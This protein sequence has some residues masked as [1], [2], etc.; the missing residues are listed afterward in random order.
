M[1]TSSY[2]EL[3]RAI[4]RRS[5][6]LKTP[7]RKN[8]TNKAQTEQ[9]LIGLRKDREKLVKEE[10]L[11]YL[12]NEGF[13]DTEANAEAL[14]DVMSEQWFSSILEAIAATRA[15]VRGYQKIPGSAQRQKALEDRKEEAKRRAE[16]RKAQV[17]KE[18][19]YARQRRENPNILKREAQKRTLSTR[20]ERAAERL[21]L[22]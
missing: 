22:D 1:D 20:M 8:Q 12:I 6:S 19:E 10:V 9:E 11:G 13:A 21:G 5:N 7:P 2:E 18:R 17:E 3:K 14:V 15:T 4:E 16:E